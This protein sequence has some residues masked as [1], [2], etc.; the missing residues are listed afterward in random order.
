MLRCTYGNRSRLGAAHNRARREMTSPIRPLLTRHTQQR[1]PPC[2]GYFA[3]E[4]KEQ[5][6][7]FVTDRIASPIGQIIVVC[8]DKALVAVDFDE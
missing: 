6:V 1:P 8:D 5:F 4:P 7:E 2:T 3:A